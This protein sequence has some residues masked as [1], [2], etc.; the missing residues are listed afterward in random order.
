LEQ[1]LYLGEFATAITTR[2]K[3]E[4][5]WMLAALTL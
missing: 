2:I 4:G 3:S 5:S 1:L